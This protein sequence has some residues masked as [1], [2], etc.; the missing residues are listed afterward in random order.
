MEDDYQPAEWEERS[1]D[2]NVFEE[3]MLDRDRDAG[4]YDQPVVFTLRIP[5]ESA[6]DLYLAAMD[7]I[8]AGQDYTGAFAALAEQLLIEAAEVGAELPGPVQGEP[9]QWGN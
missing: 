2:Y 6:G 9:N 3:R 8:E 4:E 1:D 7:A 5:E